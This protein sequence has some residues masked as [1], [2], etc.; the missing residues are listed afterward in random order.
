MLSASPNART[1]LVWDAFVRIFHW[2]VVLGFLVAYVSEGEPL[3]LHAW[4]GYVVGAAVVLRIVWGFI[5]SPHARFSD[6]VF[7]AGKIMSYLFAEMRFRARRFIGHSPAGGAMVLALLVG[8]MATTIS[9]AT[10]LA[11]QD[12]SGPFSSFIEKVESTPRAIPSAA[13]VGEGDESESPT[14][15]LW[16]EIHEIF[17]NVMLLLVTLHIG[18]VVLASFSHRENLVAAMLDGRKRPQS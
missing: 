10:L 14:V 7:P 4:A 13:Q 17:A 11:V 15:E 12:G 2:T 8:L 18:G 9:G 16:E 3:S 6:F 5:G 1:E